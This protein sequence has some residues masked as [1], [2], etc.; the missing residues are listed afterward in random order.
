MSAIFLSRAVPSTPLKKI[1]GNRIEWKLIDLLKKSTEYFRAKGIPN[2]RLNSEQLLCK[3]LGFTRIELY[4][5]HDRPVV[6][7][8]VD[9]FR[10]LVRLRGRRYPLQ[11][12]E[13]FVDFIDMRIEVANGVFIPRPETE[14]TAEKALHLGN[15]LMESAI[16]Q[17]PDHRRKDGLRILEL[18]TGTGVIGLYLA[19]HLP[20]SFV[21]A[22]DISRKALHVARHN[23]E[24][25]GIRNIAFL[26][27]DLYGAVTERN[28]CRFDMI[29]S[30]PPYIPGYELPC[31]QPEVRLYE[32][33]SSLDG[34]AEGTD[35]LERIIDD[36][37]SRSED[38][39]LLI[40]EIGEGQSGR[41]REKMEGNGYSVTIAKDLSGIPRIALGALPCNG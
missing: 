20:G 39:A 29:V 27:S 41:V 2:P 10:T 6:E 21:I 37:P 1:T 31:L 40:L 17:N 23:A 36:A 5:N 15:Q 26:Q 12:I 24:L 30:N 35:I 16:P 25:N 38:G 18:C 3:V 13:G 8:E 28:K 34:G 11:L 19:S 7:R 9:E 22:T 33:E 4:L 14:V 32:P